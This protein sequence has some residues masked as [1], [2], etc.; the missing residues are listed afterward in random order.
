[1]NTNPKNRFK[2]EDMEW[3]A[4]K[5]L[6]I[7]KEQLEAD[8]SMERLLQGMETE[9]I[10]LKLRT[11]VIDLSMDATLRLVPGSGGKPV[12]EIKGISLEKEPEA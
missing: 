12:L 5:S 8:G 1:M 6:G 10:P 9:A 4:L 3:N 7:S 11:P 2:A